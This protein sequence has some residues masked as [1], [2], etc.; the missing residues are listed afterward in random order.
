MLRSQLVSHG[1][2]AALLRFT[3]CALPTLEMASANE[4]DD[5]DDSFDCQQ[6]GSFRVL[7][8]V[9]PRIPRQF[10]L[11]DQLFEGNDGLH[12]DARSN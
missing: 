5:F 7:H 4:A 12:R 9:D 2:Y 8:D 3:D 1:R 10:L 6:F 11:G